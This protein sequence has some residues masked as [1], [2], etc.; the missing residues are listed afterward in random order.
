MTIMPPKKH[1]ILGKPS[2]VEPSFMGSA[3]TKNWFEGIR[4]KAE[5]DI[6]TEPSVLVSKIVG[7]RMETS[8]GSWG[9][10]LQE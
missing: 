4:V 6:S 8:A 10:E 5:K 3:Y 9:N 1:E 7:R 2:C